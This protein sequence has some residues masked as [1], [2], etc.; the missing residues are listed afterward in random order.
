MENVQDPAPVAGAPAAGAAEYAEGIHQWRR[1]F[2]RAIDIAVNAF[3]FFT[4]LMIVLAVGLPDAFSAF[5]AWLASIN[6]IVDLLLSV[7]I[8]AVINA[9]LLWTTGS[10]LG[11]WIFG[12]RV[13]EKDGR[14]L[15]I[16]RAFQ[17]EFHVWVRGL[18][19]G[20]PVVSLFTVMRA[21]NQVENF[22]QTTWDRDMELVV[23]HRPASTWQYVLWT[24]AVIGW[25]A[26]TVWSLIPVE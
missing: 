14:R 13:R 19:F 20:I 8:A 18:G 2:A 23:T 10:T 12:I 7:L 1:Y 15:G 9:V 5:V 26:F 6:S 21:Y 3:A 11:K 22:K 17:R 24:F 25:M 16:A 4:L